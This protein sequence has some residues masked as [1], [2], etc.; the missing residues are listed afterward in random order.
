MHE[1]VLRNVRE[2][3]LREGVAPRHVKRYVME[4]RDHLADLVERECNAGLA[5][6]AAEAKA[7]AILGTESQLVQAMLDR[8][9][10]RSVAARAPW[11]A[12]GI[13]PILLLLA[14][15]VLLG[16]ASFGWFA[17]YQDSPSAELPTSIRWL[18]L[19]VTAVGSYGIGPL[20]ALGCVIIAVRQRLAS[21]WVWVGLALV[22]LVSGPIG[23][24]IDFLSAVDGAT[25]GIR[26]ALTH[27]VQNGGRLDPGATAVLI[28]AR[29]LGLLVFSALAYRV[30]RQRIEGDVA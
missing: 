17:P 3:L 5:R 30:L 11:L 23:I 24:H 2:R 13:V 7:R 22:A 29:T 12:F 16:A 19:V 28:A 10:P 27:T 14:L 20:L 15:M 25:G 9:A 26:G 18:G 1:P 6:P 21:R 8:G 4:L